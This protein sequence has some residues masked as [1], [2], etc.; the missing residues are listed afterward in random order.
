MYD[1]MLGDIPGDGA[2]SEASRDGAQLKCIPKMGK[3][4]CI[5]GRKWTA[6]KL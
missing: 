2:G 3:T 4:R 5:G 1:R 6:G